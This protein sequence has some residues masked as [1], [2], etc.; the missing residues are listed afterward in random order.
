MAAAERGRNKCDLRS[1]IKFLLFN[2][3]LQAFLNKKGI[4]VLVAF[5]TVSLK[6][7]GIICRC[8]E[9]RTRKN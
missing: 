9:E 4:C 6:M 1:V 3:S 8:L 5:F 7:S 2:G